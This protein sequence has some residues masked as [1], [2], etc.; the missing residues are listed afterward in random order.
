MPIELYFSNQLDQLADKF[1]EVVTIECRSRENILEPSTVV[2]PNANLAKWLQ[3]FLARKLSVAMNVAFDYLETGLWGMLAALDPDRA[4]R[5]LQRLDTD[6]LKILLLHTLGHLAPDDTTFAPLIRYLYDRDGSV[7]S[8][9][10]ARI[11][12]LSEK[13]GPPVRRIRIPPHRHAPA[14]AVHRHGRDGHGSV[15]ATTLPAA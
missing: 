4:L 10:A 6:G 15:S 14:M 5:R 1:A 12:Q 3:L 8:D 9:A 2:V 13:T 11:W 7:R